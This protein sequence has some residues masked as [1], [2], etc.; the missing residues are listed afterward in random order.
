MPAKSAKQKR[1][2]QMAIH[3]PEKIR[4]KDKPTPAQA[5]KALGQHKGTKK[6]KK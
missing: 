2:L 4:Q 3:S 1:F 6:K 5:R